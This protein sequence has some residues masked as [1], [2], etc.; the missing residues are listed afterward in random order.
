MSGPVSEDL[1]RAADELREL[2]D[3][4][5]EHAEELLGDENMLNDIVANDLFEQAATH[6][7][8]AGLMDATA[9]VI[10]WFGDD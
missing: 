6:D 10:D 4:L 1:R 7:I 3:E 8:V 9:D 5:R 2:A